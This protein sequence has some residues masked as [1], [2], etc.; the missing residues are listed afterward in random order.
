MLNFS[1]EAIKPSAPEKQQRRASIIQQMF[2]QQAEADY[3]APMIMREWNA[4][5]K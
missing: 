3:E 4:R 1:S 5:G 2:L